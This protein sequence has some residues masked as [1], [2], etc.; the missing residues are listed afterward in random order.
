M[1]PALL[2]LTLPA[3][4][5]LLPIASVPAADQPAQDY[6]KSRIVVRMMA[7]DANHDGKLTL[8][9]LT[10]TRLHRLFEQAD[11]DHK[12]YVTAEDLAKLAAKLDAE[13][14]AEGRQGGFDGR[15][16]GGGGPGG[17]GPGFGGPGFGPH[18]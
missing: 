9:E 12:G 4:A 11:V 10:D 18:C 14:A 16:P 1:K 7:F 2:L 5:C 13:T 8:E 6:S 3:I 15:G 17:G